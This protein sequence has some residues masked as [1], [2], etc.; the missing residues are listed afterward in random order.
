MVDTSNFHQFLLHGHWLRKSICKSYSQ[1]GHSKSQRASL[2]AVRSGFFSAMDWRLIF[3]F[4]WFNWWCMMI[5]DD[6]WWFMM[7]HDSIDDDDLW[8]IWW[9]LTIYDLWW[10]MEYWCWKNPMIYQP[11]MFII[12]LLPSAGSRHRQLTSQMWVTHEEW[13]RTTSVGWWWPSGK[14]T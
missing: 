4:S 12:G 14:L 7:I 1:E 13:L 10:F 6:S 2:I 5:F 9:Y 8:W 11:K 3:W